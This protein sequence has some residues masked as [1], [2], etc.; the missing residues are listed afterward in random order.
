MGACLW[1]CD[2]SSICS[3]H[4]VK[5]YLSGLSLT[6]HKQCHLWRIY[7]CMKITFFPLRF[8][9]PVILLLHYFSGWI[10]LVRHFLS[11]AATLRLM[12]GQKWISNKVAFFLSPCIEWLRR[13]T[14]ALHMN[15]WDFI[16]HSIHVIVELKIFLVKIKQFAVDSEFFSLSVWSNGLISIEFVKMS[17]STQWLLL[18]FWEW[19]CRNYYYYDGATFIF[20]WVSLENRVHMETSMGRI[21]AGIVRVESKYLVNWLFVE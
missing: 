5:E 3:D 12:A 16:L 19:L 21:C 11:C 18:N 6:T 1:D 9:F 20:N 8:Y 15:L 4:A 10:S 14:K 17:Q 7:T 13:T 2:F